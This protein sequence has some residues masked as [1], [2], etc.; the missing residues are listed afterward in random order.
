MSDRDNLWLAIAIIL[1]MLAAAVT[2]PDKIVDD[3]GICN[4]P[5]AQMGC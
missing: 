3:V 1:V 2:K 5:T 4:E